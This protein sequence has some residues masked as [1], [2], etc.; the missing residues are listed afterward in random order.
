MQAHG[1]GDGLHRS[2]LELWLYTIYQVDMLR[3]DPT[4][5]TKALRLPL[6]DPVGVYIC[7]CVCV[8][9]TAATKALRLPLA[10][11]VGV[12]ICMCVCVCMHDRRHQGPALA[13]R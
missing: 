5:A 10:D 7:M 2:A 6:A 9:M 8:C 13:P 12:C 4:A 11:P 3:S 1:L